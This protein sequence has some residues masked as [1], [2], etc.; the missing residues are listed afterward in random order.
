MSAAFGMNLLYYS[1]VY[2][3]V[4]VAM[5]M[6]GNIVIGLLGTAVFSVL[7]LWQ[8]GLLGAFADQFLSHRQVSSGM[9]TVRLTCGRC[10]NLSPVEHTSG[11]L[12]LFR[13]R[14]ESKWLRY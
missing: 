5:M 6:T 13:T 9:R 12:L 2:G 10:K 8:P 4:T 7:F 1:L 3:T 14:M 11:L